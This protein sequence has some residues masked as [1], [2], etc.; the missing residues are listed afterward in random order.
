MTSI[1]SD[2]DFLS[3]YKQKQKIWGVFLGATIACVT[4]CV[5]WLIYYISL[6]YNDPM[7]TLPKVCVYSASVLYV[8]LIFPFMAIKYSRVRRYYKALSV[9]SEGLKGEEKN[10]FYCF[11]GKTLQKENIDVTS[12]IFETWSKKKQEWLER[13]VYSDA[14]KPLPDFSSGDYVQYI[15]QSNFIIQYR[16]LERGVYKFEEIKE[17]EEY[18]EED[19]L[20]EEVETEEIADFDEETKEQEEQV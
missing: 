11:E 15:V 5:A 20:G 2:A 18:E 13:E 19:Q 7:Q 16:I 17:E 3:V 8:I 4:F 12:C 14:E 1:Y 10:Y 9:F 6:P